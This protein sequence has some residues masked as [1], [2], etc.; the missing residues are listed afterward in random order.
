[1]SVA[2]M[3]NYDEKQRVEARRPMGLLGRE[4]AGG[5]GWSVRSED[6]EGVCA[7]KREI[8]RNRSCQSFEYGP[9]GGGREA[10][11]CGSCN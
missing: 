7:Y 10:K 9:E 5:L 2:G 6:G 3:S 1:M 8:E 4:K 11:T